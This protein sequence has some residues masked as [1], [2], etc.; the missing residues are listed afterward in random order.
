[1]T[2]HDFTQA[3]RILACDQDRVATVG[4]L[5]A[6]GVSEAA[7]RKRCGPGGPWQRVL[8]RVVLLRRGAP[9][10]AQRCRAALAYAGYPDV[11][12][13]LTGAVALALHGMRE[14]LVPAE[15][16]VV[17]VLVPA[18]RAVRTHTWV[19]IHHARSLPGPELVDELPVA[20]L[21]RAAGDGVRA[22]C[23]PDWMRD[24]LRELVRNRGIDPSALEDELRAAALS[25]KPGIAVALRELRLPGQARGSVTGQARTLVLRSGLWQPLWRPELRLDG[26]FLA[27]PDAFWARD[28]VALEIGAAVVHGPLDACGVRVVRVPQEALTL[29]PSQVVGALRAALAAGPH[30]PLDR[31]TVVPDHG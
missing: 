10:A 19:R 2:R 31:I 23:D 24:V 27:S 12:A 20:P 11:E 25:R 18:G 28:G 29:S 7:L 8:P 26:V 3:L 30:G 4:Q 21:V 14:V 16:R 6:I 15:V 5:A 22:S 17:D 13:Q 9:T 1:M